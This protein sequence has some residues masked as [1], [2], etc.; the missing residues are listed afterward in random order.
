[1]LTVANV[2]L[3]GLLLA[4]LIAFAGN[5]VLARMALWDGRI[6][7]WSFTAVRLMSGAIMLAVLSG[8]RSF[9]QGS[10][11]GAVRLVVYA[12]LFSLAYLKLAAGTGALILF[13]G[14]QITMIGG[15]VLR[16]ERMNV[17][18][19]AG[20][21]MAV[22]GL[23]L[24][25]QPGLERPSVS[26][27]AMMV[28]AG[29]GWGLYSLAGRGSRDPLGDTSGNFLRAVIIMVPIYL[30]ASVLGTRPILQ[31]DGVSYAVISGVVTSALGYALW[32]AVLPR[33]TAIQASV[34]Q[35]SVPVIAAIGGAILLS[36]PVTLTFAV[37]SVIVLCGLGFAAIPRKTRPLKGTS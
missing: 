32:Y 31:F 10:L 27:A 12:L 17:R 29:I 26:G 4:V 36:E 24:L 9:T 13:A 22:F 37:S 15:G 14:V 30:I 3:M 35:L 25:M 6:D 20:L 33:L 2:R 7:P 1:M 19:I 16:G 8:R 23:I 34:S 11:P 5:S 21:I 28:V 18:Q